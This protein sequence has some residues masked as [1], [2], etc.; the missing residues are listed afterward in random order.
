LVAVD[1]TAFVG[2]DNAASFF[3]LLNTERTDR[4]IYRAPGPGQSGRVRLLRRFY[5][6]KR[7]R[8]TI[9][10]PVNC[11]IIDH[12][13]QQQALREPTFPDDMIG[14]LH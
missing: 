14:R 10:Y 1:I 5:N 11:A 3:F 4:K 7:A 12:F 9:G 6:V 2:V 13:D 8:S